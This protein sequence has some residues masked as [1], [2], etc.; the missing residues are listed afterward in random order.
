MLAGMPVSFPAMR[1]RLVILLALAAGAFAPLASAAG[2]GAAGFDGIHGAQGPNEP[3]DCEDLSSVPVRYDIQYS[4]D[5]WPLGT[6]PASVITILEDVLNV[7]GG[8]TGCHNGSTADGGNIQMNQPS[9]I[10]RLVYTPSYRNFDILRVDPER[11][12]LSLMYGM[13]NCSPPPTFPAMP[14]S[15]TGTRI[16]IGLRAAV[17]DWIRAGARGRDQD[18]NLANDVL[19]RDQVESERFQQFLPEPPPLP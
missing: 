6:D 10:L 13:L 11:P 7:G 14:P 16:D 17:F 5:D 3:A 12:D 9:S 1:Q 8:C 19:F 2:P 4:M 15:M 18:G